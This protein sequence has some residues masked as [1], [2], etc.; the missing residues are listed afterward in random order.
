LLHLYC[1]P[2]NLPTAREQLFD[3][4]A[5]SCMLGNGDAHMK[6]FGVLYDGV[7]GAVRMA[8]AYDIVCT[9]LYIADDNLA[10]NLEGNRSFFAARLGLLDF[11]TRCGMPKARII[12]RTVQ[13]CEL[14]V[15][16]LASLDGVA[17]RLPGLRELIAQQT[18]I[19]LDT[20]K[21][22]LRT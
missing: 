3:M 5:L 10:L 13:L 4:V 17:R 15:A 21:R 16:T 19:W 18:Q 14:T 7:S 6:N 2:E 11:G 22:V 20:F 8:P 9:R 12:E 1:S